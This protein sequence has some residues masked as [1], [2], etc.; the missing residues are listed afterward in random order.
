M[1]KLSLVIT[2]FISLG[3]I[4]SVYAQGSKD[5]EGPIITRPV[6]GFLPI[7]LDSYD[8][9]LDGLNTKMSLIV[10]QAFAASTFAPRNMSRVRK[11]GYSVT[12]RMAYRPEVFIAMTLWPEDAFLKDLEPE[13]LTG[14][15]EGIYRNH[16]KNVEIQNYGSDYRKSGGIISPLN[17]TVRMLAYKVTDPSNGKVTQHYDYFLFHNGYL[18]E[19]STWGPPDQVSI[20]QRQLAFLA[21]D[22][23]LLTPNELA[24]IR[25]LGQR[26]QIP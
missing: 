26:R 19:L 18:L 22:L 21:N 7:Q 17:E 11:D 25:K 20:G 1:R 2:L 16:P 10:T 15:A 14:L 8:Y 24:N 9:R 13:T 23:Q 12:L 3:L 6:A 5:Y 4:Q